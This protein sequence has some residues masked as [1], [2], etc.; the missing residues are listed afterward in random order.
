MAELTKEEFVQ[1]LKELSPVSDTAA[2]AWCQW[3]SELEKMDRADEILPEWPYKYEAA[4]R[5]E[6]IEQFTVYE[7]KAELVKEQENAVNAQK[8]IDLIKQFAKPTE[9]TA[10]LL[11]TLIEKIEI[12]E[13]VKY[14]TGYREQEVAIYYRFV[15]R[16]E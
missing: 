13:A 2:Q 15:G 11:N 4:F 5:G 3:S 10:E 6:L 14:E 9:L 8:W 12:H 16:I 1:Q 7:I